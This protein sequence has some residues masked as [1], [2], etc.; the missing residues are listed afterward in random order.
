[1]EIPPEFILTSKTLLIQK[2]TELFV[3]GLHIS[4]PPHPIRIQHGLCLVEV[5]DSSTKSSYDN[6]SQ[7]GKKIDVRNI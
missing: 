2:H 1:M 4:Q 7:A 5:H 3:D 6:D